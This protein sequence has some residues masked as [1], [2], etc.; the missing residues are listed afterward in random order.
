M[1]GH[2]HGANIQHRKGAQDTK[3]A[4]SF[5][6]LLRGI[7]VA[8]KNGVDPETN[9]K[10]RTALLAARSGLVPKDKIEAAI[11]KASSD[12]PENLES[13]RYNGMMNGV[14]FIIEALTSNKNRTANDIRTLLSKNGADMV[15]TGSIEFMFNHIGLIAYP[16]NICE[17]EKIFEIII[18]SGANDIYDDTLVY[19][20]E[21]I[22]SDLHNVRTSL[23]RYFS[24]PLSCSLIWKPNIYANISNKESEEVQKVL[25][26]LNEYDDVDALYTNLNII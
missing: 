20:I 22:D 25:D 13:I 21:T 17:K 8:A 23:A 5:N 16:I 24:D 1:A 11:L 18:E 10:L 4:K 9:Y 14:A 7:H 26:I 12:N 3:K 15:E 2:S 19:Y 6:K